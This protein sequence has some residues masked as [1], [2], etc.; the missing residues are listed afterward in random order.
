[1][2]QYV[3]LLRYQFCT[4]PVVMGITLLGT[5]M[6]IAFVMLYF[7]M[8]QVYEAPFAPESNRE[9]LL[10]LTTLRCQSTGSEGSS[11]WGGLGLIVVR[12]CFYSLHSAEAV[13]AYTR[14][15]AG[16]VSLPGKGG[17]SFDV[18]ATDHSFWKVFDFTFIHGKPYRYEDL[19]SAVRVAV[20]D[21][22]I[23][24][25]LW[26]ETEVTGRSF[27]LN[28]TSYR[29][30][31]VVRPVSTSA[32]WAAAKVWIPYTTVNRSE[33][34]PMNIQGSLNLT[35]LARKRDDFPTI[36][37]ETEERVAQFNNNVLAAVNWEILTV[38]QPDDQEAALM[39]LRTGNADVSGAHRTEFL[40]FLLLLVIP[41]VNLSALLNSRLRQRRMEIGV[42]RSFGASR[43]RLMWEMF[44]ESLWVSLAGGILGLLLCLIISYTCGPW[45]FP[46]GEGID[47]YTLL[48]VLFRWKTFAWLLLV[49][50]VLNVLSSGIPVWRIV[51]TNIADSWR[52][53]QS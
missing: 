33:W 49:C 4:Q 39:R 3:T 6:S 17:R 13:T 16:Q 14:G 51:R 29:V 40:V 19:Q 30:V 21:E 32:L 18:K 5:A 22:D 38:N 36:R 37:K 24:R 9:R 47:F 20:I 10:H 12:E 42:Y 50:I 11:S 26:G 2:K 53:G 45:L 52:E 48:T 46:R 44:L 1:M 27:E 34:R 31:G 8:S 15:E 41:A 43:R 7:M 28:Y 35:I 25:F 23:A